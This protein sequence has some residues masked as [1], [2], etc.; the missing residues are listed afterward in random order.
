MRVMDLCVLGKNQTIVGFKLHAPAKVRVLPFDH[1]LVK[2]AEIGHHSAS[3]GDITCL[4]ER[5]ERMSKRYF[6]RQMPFGRQI[7]PQRGVDFGVDNFTANATNLFIDKWLEQAVQPI[8]I[9]K[10]I[11]IEKYDELA[12]RPPE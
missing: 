12:P 10:A 9:W 5:K 2:S 11:G 6:L 4:C 7:F 3:I 8:V 1:P